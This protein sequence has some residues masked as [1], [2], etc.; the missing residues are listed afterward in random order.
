MMSILTFIFYRIPSHN[1]PRESNKNPFLT[2][3]E[4]QKSSKNRVPTTT[5]KHT[6][7]LKPFGILCCQCH[8][9]KNYNNREGSRDRK[10]WKL[11]QAVPNYTILV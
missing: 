4:R 11:P 6:N 9:L 2:T 7:R 10:T 1:K 8:R 3:D 5:V